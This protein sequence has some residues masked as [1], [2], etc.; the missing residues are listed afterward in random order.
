[1]ACTNRPIILTTI[2]SLTVTTSTLPNDLLPTVAI[3]GSGNMAGAVLE[4]MLAKG[5]AETS[6][7]L[8]TTRSQSS[9]DAYANESRVHAVS[10]EHDPNANRA[11]ARDAGVIIL[12]VKPQMLGELLREIADDVKPG[13]ICISLAAGTS[14]ATIEGELAEGVRVIRAM[15]NT[16]AAIGLGAT[17]IAAG[18]H[19]D[20][21]AM[22]IA[23]TIFAAAGSVV[24]V[25]ESQIAQVAAISGSG[26]AYVYY[27]I[28][29]LIDAGVASGLDV[30]TAADLAHQTFLGASELAARR[31]DLG[32]AELR[33]RVTSPK[34]TTEQAIRVF[35]ES[36]VRGIVSRAVTANVQRS[37]ELAAEA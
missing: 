26:P 4:G 27:F 31:R 20:D 6:P 9:A 17:G 13:T 37:H 12:G 36:D 15:P 14:I 25:P 29:A 7:V 33:R 32:A 22:A 24:T 10:L 19:A 1:M 16:P 3:L 18:T 5:L 21:Q 23:A 34:G 2:D 8:V 11:A 28:E 30:D 35:D